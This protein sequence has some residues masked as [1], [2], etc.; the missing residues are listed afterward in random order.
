MIITPTLPE[1]PFD[2]NNSKKKTTGGITRKEEK[3]RR[4]LKNRQEGESSPIKR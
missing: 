2:D 3:Q 1:R 4:E